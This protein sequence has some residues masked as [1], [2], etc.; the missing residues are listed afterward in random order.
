VE[1]RDSNKLPADNN[2]AIFE[3]EFP[4][5]SYNI[6]RCDKSDQHYK[7][8]DKC[9]LADL[10]DV[11]VKE[12]EKEFEELGIGW[13]G[14]PVKSNQKYSIFAYLG[15]MPEGIIV[16][17]N[18]GQKYYIRHYGGTDLNKYV[19]VKWDLDSR[20]Y[21]QT[22]KA[23]SGDSVTVEN[24]INPA[25]TQEQW[26]IQLDPD[27]KNY[28]RLMSVAYPKKYLSLDYDIN[29]GWNRQDKPNNAEDTSLA[30]LRPRGVSVSHQG[31]VAKLV[32]ARGIV[33]ASN[34]SLF[35]NVPAYGVDSSVN[36]LAGKTDKKADSLKKY[37]TLLQN[38]NNTAT[39][40][41]RNNPGAE[42]KFTS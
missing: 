11:P 12:L 6:V 36:S 13:F 1:T 30:K 5:E 15:L 40:T 26:S 20:D 22:L 18:S 33:N 31:V 14:H 3:S 21:V 38:K 27:N 2:I 41:D 16:H 10:A 9:V 29:A 35:Y 19:L 28:F 7:I 17:R 4:A 37:K 25:N 39:V 23:N 42:L 24:G 32:F 8:T 34:K